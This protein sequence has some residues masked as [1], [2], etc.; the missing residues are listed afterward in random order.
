[1]LA[2]IVAW[3]GAVAAW[4]WLNLPRGGD[5]THLEVSLTG[6]PD[7]RH[8]IFHSGST[9]FSERDSLFVTVSSTGAAEARLRLPSSTTR[10]IRID[11]GSAESVRACTLI[12][13]TGSGATSLLHQRA[14]I[15][16]KQ[17]NHAIDGDGCLVIS[18]ES[19]A[20]DPYVVLAAPPA[21]GEGGARP[22]RI[23][24]LI[25]GLTVLA[26]GVLIVFRAWRPAGSPAAAKQLAMDLNTRLPAIYLAMA[27]LLGIGYLLVTPPGAVPDELAHATKAV[28]V[29]HGVLMGSTGNREF[30]N[31]YHMYGEFNGFRSPTKRFDLSQLFARTGQ[32]ALCEPTTSNLPSGA[33]SYGPHLYAPAAIA[34]ASSCATEAPFGAFLWSSRLGNLLIAALLTALGMWCSQRARW[35]L[36]VIA[37]MPM[38]VYQMASL[39]ADAIYFGLCFA[40]LGLTCGIA[41]NR[42]SSR[43]AAPALMALVVL[44]TFSKPGGAWLLCSILLLRPAFMRDYSRFWPALIAYLVVPA[45]AHAVWVLGAGEAAVPLAGVDP[46]FNLTQVVEDPTH[47]ARL[48]YT[49]YSGTHGIGL[50][51][52]LIGQLGWL[53]V[54]LP[55]WSYAIVLSCL[56]G[57][58]LLDR[59]ASH[60]TATRRAFAVAFALGSVI[61]ISI[62]LY[63]FWTPIDAIRI[64]GLQG[65]YFIPSLAFALPWLALPPSRNLQWVLILVIPPLITLPLLQGLLAVAVRYYPI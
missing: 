57:S 10:F 19:G 1:M 7:V 48:F 2:F 64:G 52:T 65:R 41:E 63:L 21:A 27:L 8:Q 24:G 9:T 38:S 15:R 20:T 22:G 54:I 6:A 13:G 32:P 59:S 39:S 46:S 16:A 18:P 26:V 55:T 53:D 40:W 34:Y 60:P 28:K 4:A 47:V 17:A 35:P 44:L 33:D 12:A 31:L 5:F 3:I 14:I 50:L 49:A 51:R 61:L 30:P 45:V 43:R 23:M 42:I 37:L 58:L 29:S 11:A 56:A 36:F 62:P 25:A